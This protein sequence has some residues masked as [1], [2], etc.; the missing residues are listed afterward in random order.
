MAAFK[1]LQIVDGETIKVA[2]KWSLTTQDGT[3]LIGETL[4][5]RGYNLSNSSNKNYAVDKLNKLLTNKELIL[6]NPQV[7]DRSNITDAKIICNVFVDDVDISN[8][9]PEYKL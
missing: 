6:K 3:K 9:F 2:P 5:I 7:I 8:Y 1:I 4:K